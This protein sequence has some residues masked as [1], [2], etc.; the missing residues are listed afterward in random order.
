[1][2]NERRLTFVVRRVNSILIYHSEIPG[3][4]SRVARS[5]C[6]KLPETAETAAEEVELLLLSAEEGGR[7]ILTVVS[8]VGSA[9]RE[10]PSWPA[11]AACDG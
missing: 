1:M 10:A 6:E 11:L 7:V 3:I 2:N 5:F 9:P 4:L 8:F